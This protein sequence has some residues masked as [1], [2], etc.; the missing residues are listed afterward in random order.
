MPY[1]WPGQ[2]RYLRAHVPEL[3]SYTHTYL[4]SLRPS[5][6]YQPTFYARATQCPGL[7]A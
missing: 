7:T 6:Y 5:L 1:L 3:S 4:I 2:L